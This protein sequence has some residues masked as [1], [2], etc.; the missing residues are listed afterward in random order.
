VRRAR[1]AALHIA[2]PAQDCA[3]I[4]AEN[5]AT[6][7]ELMSIFEWLT[8]KE[9]ERYAR[10]AEQKKIAA[11][12]MTMLENNGGGMPAASAPCWFELAAPGRARRCGNP[13]PA[14]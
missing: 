14:S 13:R 9:A 12:A 11:R 6:A 2:W 4:A 8:L 5:G 7:H 10:A 1:T 3:A